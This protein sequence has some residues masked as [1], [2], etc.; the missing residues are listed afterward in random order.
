[1]KSNI[2]AFFPCEVY[3]AFKS[4]QLY[5]IRM[6]PN[7]QKLSVRYTVY[8]IAQLYDHPCPETAFINIKLCKTR[9]RYEQYVIKSIKKI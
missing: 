7:E 3:E 1:M 8:R 5:F 6:F 4:F 2:T 9:E